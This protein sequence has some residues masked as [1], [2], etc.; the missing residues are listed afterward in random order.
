[1]SPKGFTAFEAIRSM[2]SHP[3][4]AFMGL[5]AIVVVLMTSIAMADVPAPPGP[6][7]RIDL[8][9]EL[10]I[11]SAKAAE[12]ASILDDSMVARHEL[13]GQMREAGDEGARQAI[14][15]KLKKLEGEVRAELAKV[16]SKEELAKLESILP[17]PPRRG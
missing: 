7:P 9:R 11:D 16:L 12:V 8:A 6:P 2:R 13:M 15:A 5:V 14:F 1:M 3:L 17:K 4:G 10:G